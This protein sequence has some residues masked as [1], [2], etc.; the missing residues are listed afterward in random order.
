MKKPVLKI[1]YVLFAAFLAVSCSS[2]VKPQQ[3][4]G[5]ISVVSAIF[6]S[7]DFARNVCG[8]A[9]E[10][11]MLISPGAD[12]HAFE[13]TAKDINRIKNCD[14]FIYTGGE[15]DAWVE[16][17]LSSFEEEINTLK[18]MDVSV[19]ERED[20]THFE[21]SE[22]HEHHH[23]E[24]DEHIWTS[25]E[26]AVKIVTAIKDKMCDIDAES[27]M[28][29]TENAKE[30]IEKINAV[31]S[32]TKAVVASAKRKTVVM[33]DRFPLLY[34]A[35]H[36]GLEV[37]AAFPGCAEKT[38]PSASTLTFLADKIRQENI[39]VV[40]KS[41]LSGGQT[42]DALCSETGAKCLELAACH[43]ISKQDFDAGVGYVDVMRKNAQ[44]LTEALN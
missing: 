3:E 39:P 32:E 10:V 43:N 18:M 27:A 7:Y 20:Y 38:E 12:V 13:P 24:Y 23:S 44:A 40:F 16:S 28:I 5:K 2:N 4:D 22:K 17:I 9:A 30:Y 31:D 15:S 14:L 37:F 29:Y 6:P 25:P 21:S 34:Y 26:N 42:A 33:G 1:I 35:K 8:D 11:S 19:L 36:Y 41:E